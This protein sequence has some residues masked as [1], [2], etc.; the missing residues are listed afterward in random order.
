MIHYLPFYVI[1]TAPDVTETILDGWTRAENMGYPYYEAA[2]GNLKFYI[3]SH[4][5]NQ[6]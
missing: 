2:M 4:R 5:T 1:F 6:W 3:Q